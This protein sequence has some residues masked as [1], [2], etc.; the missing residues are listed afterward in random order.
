[1]N[2]FKK[3]DMHAK[4][5]PDFYPYHSVAGFEANEYASKIHPHMDWLL[6]KVRVLLNGALFGST[7]VGE[8]LKSKFLIVVFVYLKIR[9]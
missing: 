3:F 4:L 9:I 6:L 7:R 5:I 2:I 1:M 8:L